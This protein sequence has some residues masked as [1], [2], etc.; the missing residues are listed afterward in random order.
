MKYFGIGEEWRRE[1]FQ[2]VFPQIE[3]PDQQNVPE[4]N[5]F[6][7]EAIGMT[8]AAGI[9]IGLGGGF[10][11]RPILAQHRTRTSPP[12]SCILQYME[13]NGLQGVSAPRSIDGK[14]SI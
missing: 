14:V 9:V 13:A 7:Q 5:S 6:S 10:L 11:A 3:Q 4:R 8:I 1:K 12:I 2:Q